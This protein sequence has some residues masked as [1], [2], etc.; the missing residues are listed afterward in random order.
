MSSGMFYLEDEVLEPSRTVIANEKTQALGL[1]L[2]RITDE[3]IAQSQMRV[4]ADS[5]VGYTMN[6][7]ELL[8]PIV[9][10]EQGRPP[11]SV[12]TDLS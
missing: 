1:C 11:C 10:A 2:S 4:K 9:R 5:S 6:P 8:Q 12:Q 7:L 3:S